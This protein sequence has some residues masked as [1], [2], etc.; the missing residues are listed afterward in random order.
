MKLSLALFALVSTTLAVTL[1]DLPKCVK[2]CVTKNEPGCGNLKCVCQPTYNASNSTQAC[3]DS[4]CSE[5]DIETLLNF[6]DTAACAAAQNAA[7]GFRSDNAVIMFVAA[8]GAAAV[9]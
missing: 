1:N 4:S 3:V 5:A 6:D 7:V 8:F 2:D 9:F